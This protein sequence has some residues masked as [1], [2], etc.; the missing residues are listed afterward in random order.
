MSKLR[1]QWAT[2][3]IFVDPGLWSATTPYAQRVAVRT[4]GPPIEVVSRLDTAAFQDVDKRR[5][6]PN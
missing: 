6:C 2:G 5:N 4:D 3:G 1:G